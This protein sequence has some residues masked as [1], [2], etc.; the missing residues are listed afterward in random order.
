M[1]QMILKAFFVPLARRQE[2]RPPH[3][4]RIARFFER[5]IVCLSLEPRNTA[6]SSSQSLG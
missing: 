1:K 4:R 3:E 5:V 6:R 2:A